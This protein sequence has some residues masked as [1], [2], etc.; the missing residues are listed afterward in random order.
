MLA[1]PDSDQSAVSVVADDPESAIGSLAY[2]AHPLAL[3]QQ[4]PF[5][6]SGTA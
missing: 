1:R 3:V 5:F 6:A 4:Q 2:V